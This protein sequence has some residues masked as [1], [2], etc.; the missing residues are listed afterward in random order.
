MPLVPGQLATSMKSFIQAAN[1]MKQEDANVAI[2]KYCQH[3]ERIVYDAIRS[4]TITIP[5]GSIV[6]VGGPTTQAN[7]NPVI[8]QGT[9]L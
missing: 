7:A 8:I 5:P 3:L 2:E 1:Q 9:I 4:I 6:T